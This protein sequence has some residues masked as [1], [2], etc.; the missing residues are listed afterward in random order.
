MIIKNQ[1]DLV[2]STLFSL[3][4]TGFGSQKVN[5]NR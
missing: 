2:P 5:P 3:F 1:N 4:T